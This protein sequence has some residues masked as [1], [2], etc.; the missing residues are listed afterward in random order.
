MSFEFF[1]SAWKCIEAD[2]RGSEGYRR[3]AAAE[4]GVVGLLLF[5]V[6]GLF[7]TVPERSS[8]QWETMC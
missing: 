7:D 8:G 2:F 6:V 5:G 1:L 4:L 3:L